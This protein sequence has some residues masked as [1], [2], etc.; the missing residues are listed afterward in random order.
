MT[1][2]IQHQYRDYVDA[3]IRDENTPIIN[4]LGI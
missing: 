4:Y 3:K 2:D 1:I